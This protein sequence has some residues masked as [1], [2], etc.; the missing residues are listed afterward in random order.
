MNQTRQKRTTKTNF[1]MGRMMVREEAIKRLTID[2]GCVQE[3]KEDRLGY[4]HSGWW[5]DDVWLAKDPIDAYHV[6]NDPIVR[7]ERE[8]EN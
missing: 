2:Y 8:R 1:N 5:C 6:L 4:T 3:K 7:A